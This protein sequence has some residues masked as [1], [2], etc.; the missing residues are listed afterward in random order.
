MFDPEDPPI[1]YISFYTTLECGDNDYIEVTSL[2]VSPDTVSGI[3]TYTVDLPV[4]DY[5][6]VASSEGFDPD[7]ATGVALTSGASVDIDLE[8]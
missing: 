7:T 4:G 2:S 6:V 8:L 5:D 1:V 3:Y